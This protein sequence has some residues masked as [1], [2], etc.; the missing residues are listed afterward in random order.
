MERR[1]VRRSQTSFVGP[2]GAALHGCSWEP[3]SPRRRLL[4]VHD[5][6]EHSGRWDP[7]GA[8]FAAR[9]F[10]VYAFDQSG[11]GRSAGSRGLG[12]P[13]G[14]LAELDG[15]A[16]RVT[17][18]HP[19]LPLALLG[20]GTGALIALRWLIEAKP[21]VA[22]A[23]LVGAPLDPELPIRP[24]PAPWRRAL[25]RIR[26]RWALA[27]PLDPTAL[28]RDPTVGRD[29]REDARVVARVPA[30]TVVALRELAACVQ[31]ESVPFPLWLAHGEADSLA[32]VRAARRFYER[33]PGAEHCLR[34]YPQLRH[35]IL[36]EPE[37]ET[38]LQELLQWLE[39][40]GL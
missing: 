19:D 23:A 37:N 21:A 18:Q 11:H 14:W 9:D 2:T 5:L 22:A 33:L 39:A 24:L 25:G 20:G 4:L 30:R 29:Y 38:V 35:E 34:V 32:P 17:A 1:I 3:A 27:P 10:A 40:R 12:D 15:F 7:I 31:G 28:S 13:D 36:H 6:G 8:W 16:A 26:P